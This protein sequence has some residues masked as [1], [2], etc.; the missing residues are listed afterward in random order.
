M[1]TEETSKS[2]SLETK[3]CQVKDL[4]ETE[5]NKLEESKVEKTDVTQEEHVASSKAENDQKQ[6]GEDNT[7]KKVDAPEISEKGK[8][9]KIGG[10]TES[11]PEVVETQVREDKIDVIL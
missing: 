1:G 10:A 2:E 7:K 11:K 3:V 4:A 9:D 5:S 8:K 6:M